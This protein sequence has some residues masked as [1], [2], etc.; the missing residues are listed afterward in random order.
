MEL[1]RGGGRQAC[2]KQRAGQTTFSSHSYERCVTF[3]TTKCVIINTR[4]C[5]KSQI[6]V[7]PQSSVDSGTAALR[8]QEDRL[9]YQ[10][11]DR[12]TVW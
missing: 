4:I 2:I 3:N 10:Q 1:G 6:Y 8:A 5:F 11:Q 7:L 9:S 12:Q